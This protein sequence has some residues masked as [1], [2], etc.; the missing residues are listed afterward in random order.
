MVLADSGTSFSAELLGVAARPPAAAG[1][2]GWT[3]WPPVAR[4]RGHVPA[5]QV[6]LMAITVDDD[7]MS[8]E[9]DGA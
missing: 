1:I 7:I 8:W 9:I 2:L 3:S 5:V 4:G 6:W